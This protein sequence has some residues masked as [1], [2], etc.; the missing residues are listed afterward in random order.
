MSIMVPDLFSPA[1]AF[2]LGIPVFEAAM[3]QAQTRFEVIEPSDAH[4][5]GNVIKVY[6]V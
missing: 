5:A 6:I 1:I 4:A 2:G 3:F